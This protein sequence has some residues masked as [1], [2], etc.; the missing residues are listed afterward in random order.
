MK[1]PLILMA[2]AL[3]SAT[4]AVAQDESV[5]QHDT[6][7]Q[8]FNHLDAAINMGSTGVGIDLSMPVGSKVQVRTGFTFVPKFD[9][10]MHFGIQVGEDADPAVQDTKFNKLSN[11]L[12]QLVGTEVDRNVDMIGKPSFSNF[13]LLVDVFPFS[14][15]HWH[16]TGGFYW[17]PSKIAKAENAAY[18]AT[19]MVAMAMYNNLYDRIVYSYESGWEEPYISI[20]GNDLYADEN[21]YNKVVS[22]GRMGV[23]VGDYKTPTVDKDG[24]VTHKPYMMEPDEN[25]TVSAVI[26]V[27]SFRPYLGFGYEG[28]L[29]KR[30]DDRYNI[31]FDFGLM[32]WG[33]TP[34]IITHDGTD[35]AR[36]VENISGKVG[37]YVK[38]FKA[39]KAYPVLNLKISR[40]LF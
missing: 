7:D 40:R 17:G 22:Y 15:K 19:G 9:Y 21:L 11:Y 34:K 39:F 31:G 3:F 35:L 14:N 36:D 10:T 27:N 2:T 24:N 12:K 26:K 29:T 6:N 18:D 25:N 38:F 1:R 5:P 8:L 20:G 16:V 37:D 4:F 30:K 23:H 32:F 33:G 13:K 28:A